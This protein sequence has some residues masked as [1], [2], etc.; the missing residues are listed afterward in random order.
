MKCCVALNTMSTI[1]DNIFI[2]LRV[3][4]KIPE[5]GK[6]STIS[7][8]QVKLEDEGYT[9]TIWRTLTR[10]S[11]TK[12]I[13]LLMGLFNDVNEYSDNTI[14]SLYYVKQYENDNLTMFQL[15]ENARKCHTLRKLVRELGN[16]RP[17]LKNLSNTYK[18]DPNVIAGI[19]EIQDKIDLQITKIQ[20]ALRLI[21]PNGEMEDRLHT[22]QAYHNRNDRTVN[23]FNIYGSSPNNDVKNPFLPPSTP[24]PTPTSNKNVHSNNTT[25]QSQPQSPSQSQSPSQVQPHPYPQRE[26]QIVTPNLIISQDNKIERKNS[27]DTLSNSISYDPFD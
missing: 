4:A 20:A 22:P 16:A 15:N 18:D 27:S 25:P 2:N 8:G 17:G 19:E 5:N 11:R 14:S 12:S 3:I 24:T 7:P 23:T 1:L 10:D 26:T 21:D 9:T 13:K 6:I